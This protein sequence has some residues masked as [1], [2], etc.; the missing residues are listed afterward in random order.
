VT[1]LSV[2]DMRDLSAQD[3]K[4][5]SVTKTVLDSTDEL[6]EFISDPSQQFVEAPFPYS[7]ELF[8]SKLE[9]IYEIYR[10]LAQDPRPWERNSTR[11]EVARRILVLA[12][13]NQMDGA[14]L[15]FIE[16]AGETDSVHG[17][18]FQIWRDEVGNGKPLG[19]PWQ[20]LHDAA[21]R[22]RLRPT[23]RRDPRLR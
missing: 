7:D 22:A 9:E 10:V 3:R 12:P 16:D 20:P 6:I 1:F 8:D 17:L 4:C 21:A 19:A 18:L 13:F 11:S 15:R 23:R 5:H 2:R 14:W